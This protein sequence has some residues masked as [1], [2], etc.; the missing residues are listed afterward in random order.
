MISPD[1][2]SLI[3][4]STRAGVPLDG[5]RGSA[6]A[7]RTTPAE[8]HAAMRDP[9]EEGRA[10]ARD[11]AA[12]SEEGAA[13][14]RQAARALPVTEAPRVATWAGVAEASA[15]KGAELARAESDSGQGDRWEQIQAEAA[16]YAP[17]PFGRYLWID[18]KCIAAGM[19]ATGRWWRYSIGGLYASGKPW[20]FF[21]VGR[22][23]GKSTTLEKF[24]GE[25]SWLTPR[26]I[27]PGQ[28]WTWP[29]ISI[30]PD[31]A[32]RR[33]DGLAA[34]FRA[35]GLPIIGEEDSSGSK[36]RDGVKMTRAPRG[37]LSLVDARG[38]PI[39]LASI[40]GTIGN[41]SGP[42]TIG[43]TIDEAAKLHDKTTNANPL[44]EIVASGAQTS[45]GRPDWQ[46]IVSSSVWERTGTF[47]LLIEQ[48]PNDS[49]YVADIGEEFLELAIGG[50]EAVARWEEQGGPGRKPDPDAATRIRAH[51]R[52]LTARSPMIPTWVANETFGNPEGVPWEGGALASR[53]LVE[54]LPASALGG[55]PRVSFW[56]RENGSV[57]MD[58]GAGRGSAR[59]TAEDWAAHREAM[60]PFA[61]PWRDAGEDRLSGLTGLP[62][63]S[64][65][66]RYRPL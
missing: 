1:P 24:S 10:F 58:S 2:R 32:N 38:N 63:A 66:S 37:S 5:P 60:R 17:G 41:V 52:S 45:R 30:G 34:V 21:C 50:F 28:T 44:A 20:G 59:W 15:A 13:S 18:A 4:E 8:V 42:S 53:K 25:R 7:A 3:L 11:M 54:V 56:L 12:A 61:Q 26:R 57:P 46:A 35:V 29:F 40:A 14:I 9:S 27:P 31:D 65:P 55:I 64:S 43:L 47:W 23:G 51:A 36:Q 62:I 49:N 48:G 19:P 6:R 22:G 16:R 33:V 39:Q